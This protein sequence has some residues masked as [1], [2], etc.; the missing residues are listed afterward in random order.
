VEEPLEDRGVHNPKVVDLIGFDAVERAVVLTMIETRPWG[1]SP[2]Q[3]KQVEDKFNSYLSYV[4]AGHLEREYPQYAGAPVIFRL[5]C[6]EP[7]GEQERAFLEAVTE[8][9]DGEK[10]RF[11]VR[12]PKDG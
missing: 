10:I 9:A 7:P 5:D 2:D 1:A 4:A 11:V 8:F 12:I 6:V 3:I